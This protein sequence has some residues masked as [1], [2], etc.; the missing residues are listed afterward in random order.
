MT[1][2]QKAGKG[3]ADRRAKDGA[4]VHATPQARLDTVDL[5]DELAVELTERIGKGLQEGGGLLRAADGYEAPGLQAVR[6]AWP[7]CRQRPH[8]TC[9]IRGPR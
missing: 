1:N 4:R 3:L 6:C 7:S 2:K 5:A 9:Q 8:V